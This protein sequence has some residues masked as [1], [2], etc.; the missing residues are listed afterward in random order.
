MCEEV[1]DKKHKAAY[2]ALE[3]LK[4]KQYNKPMFWSRNIEVLV[5]EKSIVEDL[6][7]MIRIIDDRTRKKQ[8]S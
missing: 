2:E 1:T 4:I 8:R 6:A 3:V 5:K 7:Q